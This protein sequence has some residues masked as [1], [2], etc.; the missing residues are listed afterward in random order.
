MNIQRILAVVFC[1]SLVSTAQAQRAPSGTRTVKIK[2]CLVLLINEA[3]LPAKEGG[4]IVA[5]NVKPGDV[6]ENG[7]VLAEIDSSLAKTQKRV[8]ENQYKAAY[9]QAHNDVDV[10]TNEAAVGVAKA[11]Y[12][13]GIEVNKKTPNTITESE[14]RRRLFTWKRATL[15]VE[16]AVQQMRIDAITTIVRGAE[17]AAAELSIARRKVASP[18]NG[19]VVEVNRHVGEWAAPGEVVMHVVNLERLRVDG[20]VSVED[21]APHE[22]YQ[23]P[24]TVTVQEANGAPTAFHGKINFVSPLVAAN[25]Y[26]VSAE[27]ENK[28]KLGF[29]VLRPGVAPVMTISLDN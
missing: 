13:E 29:W 1:L 2:D 9:E 26:R 15:Q 17:L 25:Q 24:V 10:R 28:Q 4:V 22:I 8:A 3:Q 20:F 7:E 12:E 18:L 19:T 27:I 21:F 11:E 5:I 16:Q 23:K 14:M 6:V